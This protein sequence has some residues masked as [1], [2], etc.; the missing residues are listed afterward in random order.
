M[1]IVAFDQPAIPATFV[2]RYKRFF[3]DVLAPGINGTEILTVHCANS[4]SMKSCLAEG[5]PCL[6]I[7]SNN[8]ARKLRYGLEGIYLEDGWACL[9]TLRANQAF[10]SLMEILLQ[11][12]LDSKPF[13]G[14]ELLVKDFSGGTFRSEAVFDAGTRFDGCIQKT[15]GRKKWIE[16]KS[17]SLRL[18]ADTIAFPDAVTMRGTRHLQ[19]LQSIATSSN[20]RATLIYAIM[21]G[22]E[23]P[24]Q[25]LASQFA[26][27]REIDPNYAQASLAAL[28]SGVKIRL[29]VLGLNDNGIFVRGYFPWAPK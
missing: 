10:R 25:V 7:D 8:P 4:G 3:C 12:K 21:R 22:S 28:K 23:L 11:G 27:A 9:N 16:L 13:S 18:S 15:D 19:K 17:V 6:I 5:A 14:S 1:Q 29:L 2:R 20:D 26:V 24:A